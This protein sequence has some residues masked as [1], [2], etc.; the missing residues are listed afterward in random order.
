MEDE[1]TAVVQE[2]VVTG[3]LFY[4]ALPETP[5]EETLP[6]DDDLLSTA[7]LTPITKKPD[8]H[9][10]TIEGVRLE[11]FA[12]GATALII[13]VHSV[14]D[15]ALETEKAIFLPEG[16]VKDINVDPASLPAEEGN[17]QR[18]SYAIHVSASDKSATLQRLRKTAA[19]Q[20]RRASRRPANIQEFAEMHSEVLTG[21]MVVFTRK[22]NP[23]EED[24]QFRN[25]LK[26]N[27]FHDPEE[28]IGNPKR[29]KGYVKKWEQEV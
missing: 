12:S 19:K 1:T 27:G 3:N 5:T 7:E 16:F 23:K 20:G 17:N 26:I 28:V 24:P 22:T 21:I 4:D 8:A 11:T 18:S 10:A 6:A 13:S 29:L 2:E 25:I 9:R 15:A 14:D